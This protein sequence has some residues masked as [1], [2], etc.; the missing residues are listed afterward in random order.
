ME[1]SDKEK[2]SRYEVAG[3]MFY[4]A[5]AFGYMVSSFTSSGFLDRKGYEIPVL[6]STK[7][8]ALSKFYLENQTTFWVATA[9]LF[10]GTNVWIIL[11]CLSVK[12]TKLKRD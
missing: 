7:L 10:I 5:H 2:K 12:K 3:R 4:E 9:S 6:R 1:T 8:E 11:K